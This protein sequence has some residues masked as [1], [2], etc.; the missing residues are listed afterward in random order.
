MCSGELDGRWMAWRGTGGMLVE[1]VVPRWPF[2][3]S[4]VRP[5]ALATACVYYFSATMQRARGELFTGIE[6][7]TRDKQ[8]CAAS[9]ARLNRHSGWGLTT[10]AR[11]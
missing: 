3:C 6:R 4:G 9:C 2:G 10:A 11:R 7:F 8:Y 1:V 5:V